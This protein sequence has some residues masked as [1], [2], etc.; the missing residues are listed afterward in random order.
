MV[1]FSQCAAPKK[2]A[3]L[4]MQFKADDMREKMTRSGFEAHFWAIQISR[5][6][7]HLTNLHA[8][9]LKYFQAACH[10]LFLPFTMTNIWVVLAEREMV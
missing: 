2:Q 3:Q 9:V 8:S 1:P 10:P 7:L 5:E 4:H 6:N